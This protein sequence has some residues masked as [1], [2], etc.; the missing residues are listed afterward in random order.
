MGASVLV[1]VR[2]CS[3]ACRAR[4]QALFVPTAS[5]YRALRGHLRAQRLLY[6]EGCYGVCRTPNM[7]VFRL[8]SRARPE[9]VSIAGR[10]TG[11]T[12]DRKK[13]WGNYVQSLS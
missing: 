10:D 6:R 5:L 4:P 7:L 9:R 2:A 11:N 1:Y 13:R 8:L 12:L 3:H